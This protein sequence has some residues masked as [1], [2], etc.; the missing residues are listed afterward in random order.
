MARG[1]Q[2]PVLVAGGHITF[3]INDST[4]ARESHNAA[5]AYYWAFGHDVRPANQSTGISGC[6][7]CHSANSDFY[8]SVIKPGSPIEQSNVRTLENIELLDVNRAG[9]WIFS[10]SFLFRPWLK[11]LIIICT[12]IML[13]V[14]LIYF[15]KVI[16]LITENIGN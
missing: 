10:M 11:V 7:D 16:R 14:L 1:M 12:T 15:G 5:E 6:T 13:T 3:L 9:T 8:Y 2:K 4:L